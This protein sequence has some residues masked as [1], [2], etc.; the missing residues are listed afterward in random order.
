MNEHEADSKLD[1]QK[2]SG[3]K[4]KYILS[5]LSEHLKKKNINQIVFQSRFWQ[6]K[7]TMGNAEQRKRILFLNARMNHHF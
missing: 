3:K 6:E 7:I 5:G 1:F 2:K 4:K